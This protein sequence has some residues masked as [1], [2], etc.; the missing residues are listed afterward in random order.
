MAHQIKLN[1][2]TFQ[3]IAAAGALTDDDMA[4]LIGT[5]TEQYKR[6]MQGEP[7][8]AAFVAR[9]ALA[10]GTSFYELFHAEDTTAA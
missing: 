9:A 3:N 6:A 2:R 10:F 5:T 7:V 4:A 1:R 8:P